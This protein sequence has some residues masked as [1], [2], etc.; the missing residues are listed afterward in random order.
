MLKL[1]IIPCLDVK[2]GKVVKGVRFRDQVIVGDILDL[3]QK[4]SDEGAD[5]LV[6]Y[7][8][9]ASSDQRT[10]DRS[11]ISR[12]AGVIQIP[13]CVA[14]GIRT[15][16]DAESVFSA[17]ADK[18]SIN[19][20]ALENPD[21]IDRLSS[22]FGRQSVVVSIDSYFNG[23]DYFV[24]QYTGD[25]SKTRSTQRRTEDW[26]LE[27]EKRGAGEMVLNCMNQD[28]MRQGYDVKQLST[29]ASRL[30]I[31]LVASGGAGSM[32]DFIDLFKETLVTGALAASVFHRGV[33]CIPELKKALSRNGIEVRL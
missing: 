19:S 22:R 26:A 12:V 10:V 9:S 11:W 1:R 17:G 20:P 24:Y 14:G 30:G 13:F 23:E 3:A 27:A 7:D 15:I 32:E 8:I 5:E 6:F 33:I 2:D 21:L 28:G 31:P 4:Y 25:P 18:V 16:E 29:L